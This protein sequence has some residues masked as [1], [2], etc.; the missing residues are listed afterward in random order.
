[1]NY[2]FYRSNNITTR[3]VGCFFS[4]MAVAQKG[5]PK[6]PRVCLV[7][8]N[9]ESKPRVCFFMFFLGALLFEPNPSG[10]LA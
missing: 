1:M 8:N 5:L 10:T 6:T 9:E 2:R 7:R 4:Q 3:L